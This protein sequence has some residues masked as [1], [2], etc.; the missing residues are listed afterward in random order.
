MI[1]AVNF[2]DLEVNMPMIRWDVRNEDIAEALAGAK[3]NITQAAR[4]LGCGDG[5]VHRWLDGL[6]V[7]RKDL[8]RIAE[9]PVDKRCTCC[10]I[11]ERNGR[12]LCPVCF[13]NGDV[14]RLYP[15]ND[16]V[17]AV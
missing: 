11:R 17:C 6:R 2:D 1:I 4:A 16:G 12:F 5:L 13:S 15:L 14:G 10:G 9:I 8:E 7:E 3:G